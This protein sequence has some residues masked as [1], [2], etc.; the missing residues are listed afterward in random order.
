MELMVTVAII[1]ALSVI[2]V[3]AY[4]GFKAKA[5][6]KEGFNL[7]NGYYTAATAIRAEYG[8]FPGNLVATS[9]AP[10]GLLSYRLR[11]ND[12]PNNLPGANAFNNDDNCWNTDQTAQTCDCGGNCPNFRT[13]EEPVPAGAVGVRLGVGCVACAPLCAMGGMAI[14]NDTFVVGIAGVISTTSVNTDRY[15]MNEKKE[16]EMCSDGL[17]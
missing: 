12:N 3:P 13:W 11:S 16:I 6:Q 4:R 1:A 10:V 15:F 5:I 8:L 7:L 9:F 2:A 17:K 14:S